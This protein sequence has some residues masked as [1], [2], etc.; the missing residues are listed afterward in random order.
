MDAG[1]AAAGQHLLRRAGIPETMTFRVQAPSSYWA[2][3]YAKRSA[4]WTI[5]IYQEGS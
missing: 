1:T 2:A 5:G 4:S 3:A